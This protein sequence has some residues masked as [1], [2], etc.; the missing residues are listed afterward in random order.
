MTITPSGQ[1]IDF[2][3]TAGAVASVN[4]QTGAVLI[5]AGTGITVN[6]TETPSIEIVNNSPG[7]V[8]SGTIDQ[9]GFSAVTTGPYAGYG[10]YLKQVTNA[11]MNANGLILATTGGTPLASYNAWLITVEPNAGGFDIYVADDPVVVDET[12]QLHYGIISYGTAP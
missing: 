6:N 7:F 5:E 1:N 3:V 4:S 8:E 2:E 12:W 9:T 11:S 10:F